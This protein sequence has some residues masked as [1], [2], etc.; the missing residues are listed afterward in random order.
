V[1]EPAVN[2]GLVRVELLRAV[3]ELAAVAGE[4]RD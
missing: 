4:A 1:A 2:V 3:G